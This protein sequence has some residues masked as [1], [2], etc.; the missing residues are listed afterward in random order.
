MTSNTRFIAIVGAAIVVL[1]GIL[2]Y[3]KI[4]HCQAAGGTACCFGRM[5][6][7]IVKPPAKGVDDQP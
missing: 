7:Q 2:L 5:C 3:Q 6:N 1:I 4:L